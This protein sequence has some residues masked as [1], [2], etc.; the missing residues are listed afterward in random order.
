[1]STRELSVLGV[2]ATIAAP[3]AAGHVISEAEAKALNQTRAENI[4]NSVRKAVGELADLTD[5]AGKPAFSPEAAAKA[6]A[7][8]T[9]FD[10]SYVFSLRA[11]GGGS[12]VAVD[13]VEKEATAIA[14]A[15]VTEQIK[16][17]GKSVKDY[18]KDKF[19]ALVAQVASAEKTRA[20]AKKRV[21]E[22]QKIASGLDLEI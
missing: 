2:L 12:R 11:A 13:P 7:L 4:S 22:R 9:E 6:V 3:Y 19:A 5:E 18:D 14:K 21:E 16:A 15:Y 17:K 8:I 1:M 10:A 20:L